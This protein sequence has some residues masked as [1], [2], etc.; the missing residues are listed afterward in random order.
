VIKD[1]PRTAGWARD[2]EDFSA[3]RDDPEFAKL[4]A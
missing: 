3:L 2:D 4:V 1:D